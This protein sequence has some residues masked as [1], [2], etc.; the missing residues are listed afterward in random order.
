VGWAGAGQEVVAVEPV[1]A[2]R[3][4]EIVVDD[5]SAHQR[6]LALLERL[7]VV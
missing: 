3:S 6:I 2:G 1:A 4:V 7:K 5:G